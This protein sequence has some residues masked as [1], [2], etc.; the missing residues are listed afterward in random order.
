MPI[1]SELSTAVK[2]QRSEMGLTQER[3]ADLA[4][5][6]RAT[7]NELETGKLGNLSLDRAERLVN[8]LGLGLGI[9]GVKRPSHGQKDIGIFEAAARAASVSYGEPMPP[10]AL[11][12]ALLTGVIAPSYIPQ[13]RAFLDEAPVSILSAAAAEMESENGA[14]RKATWQKMRQLAAVLACTRG[15]WR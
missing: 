11:R 10:E 2:R 1:L 6:S 12:Q 15:I 3:L 14:P 9:T 8:L 7:V 13:L 5:L 4:G